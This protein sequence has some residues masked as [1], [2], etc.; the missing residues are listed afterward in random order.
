M[1]RSDA[2]TVSFVEVELAPER[3][4]MSYRPGSPCAGAPA[5]ELDWP[6]DP[7]RALR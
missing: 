4:R 2:A 7:V 6:L 1:H 5:V 3:M